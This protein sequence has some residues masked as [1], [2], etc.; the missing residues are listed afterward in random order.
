LDERQQQFQA[1]VKKVIRVWSTQPV[2]QR[3]QFFKGRAIRGTDIKDISF[4]S[5][6]GLEMTDEDWNAGSTKCMG[7]RL[8]GD[9]IND[10][11]ERGEPIV[12]DM[13]LLL[14]NAHHEPIAFTLPLTKVDQIWEHILDTAEDDGTPIVLKGQERMALT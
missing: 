9:L 1:F 10:Q 14:L 6:S 2:F 8:A 4:L 13:L 5:P 11:D 3:R 7:V 12:G